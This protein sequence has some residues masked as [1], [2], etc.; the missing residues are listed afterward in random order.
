[1]EGKKTFIGYDLGDGE[2]ITDYVTMDATAAKDA[3]KT[4]FTA[5]TMPDLNDPG[6]ALPTTYGYDECG[7]LV[8][9]ESIKSM[10]DLVND[11]QIN[12]KRRPSDLLPNLSQK[13]SEELMILFEDAKVWPSQKECPEC[14]TPEMEAFR[15]SVVTFTNAVFENKKY[16]ERVS[17]EARDSSEIVFCV[18]HPTK[19]NDLDVAIYKV[20]LKSSILGKGSYANKQTNLIMAAESRAAFLTIKDKASDNVLPKGTSALLIDVGS[21]TIDLT[22]MTSNS[23]NYQYN[24]GSNYLGVRCID[25]IIR[26]MYL[27]SL[28]NKPGE[29]Q[30]YESIISK[31]PSQVKALTLICRLAKEQMYSTGAG[32]STIYFLDL[33]PLRINK[34]DVEQAINRFPVSQ[35]LTKNI[36]LPNDQAK[37][38]DNKN[39]KELFHDFLCEQKSEISKQGIKIGRIILT[40]SASKMTF[41]PQI[42]KDV[43]NDLP[44][45]GVLADMDP[46]R[47]IS[48]GL[49]LVGPSNEKSLEFQ[50]DLNALIDKE[51]PQIIEQDIPKLA[52]DLSIVINNVVTDIVKKD[53]RLWRS[54]QIKTLAEMTDRI[55]YDCNE[56][57]LQKDLMNNKAYNDAILKWTVEVVGL[58]IAVRLQEI[59]RRY[60]VRNLTLEDLNVMD[61]PKI[62]GVGVNID[63]LDFAD[64][65]IAIVSVIAGIITAIVLPTVL[66]IVIGLISWISVGIAGFLLTILLSIP[67]PGWLVLLAVAGIAVVRSAAKGLGSAK[68]ELLKKMQTINLPQWIRDRLTDE[69]IAAEITKADMKSKIKKS[70]LEEKSKKAIV[71]SVARNLSGQIEKRAEDIKYVIESI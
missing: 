48:M 66:G 27:E 28:R 61:I 21:S 7:N 10:P 24:S 64:T 18:G 14:Y 52:D 50:K 23:H 2:S 39:W 30:K 26:E 70:I 55:E 6:R 38:M 53:M 69:K 65:I 29:Y 68:E 20:I 37:A 12:F 3:V 59:C 62:E 71:E 16:L 32:V 4:F 5:M 42:V 51:L 19:W 11:V 49:S 40:G 33:P 35:I 36:S 43:F 45:G 22:A 58:D 34:A 44:Q 13:R 9:A 67:G 54:S 63:V 47:S 15:K 25:Y 41:V 8:F 56:K 60:G 57:Q 31:N 17:S 1:M 46:S